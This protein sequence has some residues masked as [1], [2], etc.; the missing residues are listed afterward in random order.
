MADYLAVCVVNGALSVK[1]ISLTQQVQN[2]VGALFDEQEFAFVDGVDEEIDFDGDWKPDDNQV[3]VCEVTD[4]AQVVADA[5]NGNAL[6]LPQLD[7]SNFMDEGV[8]AIVTGRGRAGNKRVLV[9][10]FSPQQILSKKFALLL[11][12]NTFKRLDQPSFSLNT[13]LVAMI[14]GNQIKFKSFHTVRAIFDL[15]VYYREA[16][17]EDI[18]RLSRHA[19]LQI[20]NV[21]AF[22]QLADQ[23]VRK[24]VHAIEKN[25]VL[26]EHTVDEVQTRASAVGLEIIVHDGRVQMPT[27]KAEVKRLLQF[28][29]DDIYEA[30]LSGHR[31]VTNSKRPA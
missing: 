1:R 21:D 22:K 2:Q 6:A 29:H 12:N 7:A 18:D 5:V 19:A 4:G 3:L 11:D 24:L 30:P 31:Y 14:D 26:D 17:N 16:T 28:L 13:S 23:Q 15:S 27:E 20:N 25:G 9:Q 8:K 10:K